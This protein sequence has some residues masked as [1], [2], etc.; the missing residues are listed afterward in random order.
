M[1]NPAP[2]ILTRSAATN[3]TLDDASSSIYYIDFPAATISNVCVAEGTCAYGN[4][5]HQASLPSAS[6]AFQFAGS[7][8]YIFGLLSPTSGPFTV[9]VDGVTYGSLTGFCET[10]IAQA[11]LFYKENLDPTSTHQVVLR[12]AASSLLSLDYVIATSGGSALGPVRN[13]PSSPQDGTW[14]TPVGNVG[15]AGGV[16]GPPFA[17]GTNVPPVNTST[18]PTDAFGVPIATPTEAKNDSNGDQIGAIIG[19]VAGV[20]LFLVIAW[21]LFRSH[22]KKR[23]DQTLSGSAFPA[24]IGQRTPVPPQ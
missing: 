7:A 4:T 21:M 12:N 2:E 17:G 10:T 20:I 3:F 8:F 16:I 5:L 13:P 6:A 15:N 19:A 18:P 14:G 11:L 23:A 22:K 24:P 1:V 9:T